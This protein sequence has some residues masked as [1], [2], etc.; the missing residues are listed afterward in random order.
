V[1]VAGYTVRILGHNNPCNSTTEIVRKIFLLV[2]P[3]I[4]AATIYMILGCT[5]LAIRAASLSPL[6]PTWMTK[7]FVTGDIACFFIQLTGV[8]IMGNGASTVDL[9]RYI[10]L[11]GLGL[12]ILL[13]SLFVCIAYVFHMRIHRYPT[14]FSHRPAVQWQAM[15]F[16]LYSLSAIIMFRNI[17]RVVETAG[18]RDGYL[19]SHEWPLYVFDSISMMVVMAVL[20]YYFHTMIRPKR[21]CGIGIENIEAQPVLGN[22]GKKGN[23]KVARLFSTGR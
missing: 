2:A 6:R 19:L 23:T 3:C 7:V 15:L 18:G 5:I 14:E 9:G 22:Q 10:T 12:Q 8:A 17:F 13:F 16:V 1:E 21:R 11:T 20:L 4:F